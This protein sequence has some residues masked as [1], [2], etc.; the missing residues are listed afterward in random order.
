[1][2]EYGSFWNAAA[3]APAEA[4]TGEPTITSSER[5]VSFQ[6]ASSGSLGRNQQLKTSRNT[7]G[8][9]SP[10]NEL[11][12]MFK[13]LS[14][15]QSQRKGA[16]NMTGGR[17]GSSPRIPFSPKSTPNVI[18]PTMIPSSMI[19]QSIRMPSPGGGGEPANIFIGVP[20]R[21]SNRKKQI[22]Q[23]SAQ[24]FMEQIK[25]V[26]QSLKCRNVAFLL[27]FVFHLVFVGVYLG[28]KFV[29]EA[30]IF[31]DPA[32]NPGMVT[33]LYHNLLFV[34]ML[35]GAF[36]IIASTMLLCAMTI[37]AR[38]FL[39][40]SLITIIT[41]SFIWGTLG[42]G[43][44]P[45]TVVPVTGIIALG[46]AVAYTFIVWDRIPFS[47]TNLSSALSGI[48]AFPSTVFLAI[49]MQVI[50]LGWFIYFSLVASGLYNA[51]QD[52]KLALPKNAVFPCYIL[53]GLSFYWTY[54]VFHVSTLWLCL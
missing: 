12:K 51:I 9:F 1:M 37:F 19:T 43:L 24:Q 13:D 35:S 4:P 15:V 28:E 14:P 45:K 53:L 36:A 44:S 31:H 21:E 23:Q 17:V 8:S 25:G 50:T 16:S 5:P 34:A 26:E 33:I 11:R 20:S 32:A 38:N 46:L 3:G 48:R 47:A 30:F 7:Q 40:I 18:H 54:Q 52:G 27:L 6:A 29:N 2:P 49:F 22:R 39:Q 10:R 41:L 42:V